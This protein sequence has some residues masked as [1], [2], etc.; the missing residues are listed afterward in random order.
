[1]TRQVPPVDAFPPRH[2]PTSGRLDIAC[3]FIEA[4]RL[5]IDVLALAVWALLTC[6]AAACIGVCIFVLLCVAC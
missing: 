1:M 4:K 6:L 2:R 5:V 3:L